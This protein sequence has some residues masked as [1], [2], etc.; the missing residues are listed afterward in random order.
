MAAFASSYIKTEGSQVT[1]SAD[2]A[3]M[4]GANFSSWY[5]ADEGTFFAEAISA[6]GVT[7]PTQGVVGVDDGST[8][9]N[10]FVGR[11]SILA[12]RLISRVGSVVDADITSG[13]WANLTTLRLAAALKTNDYALA[14]SSGAIST[15]TSVLMPTGMTRLMIGDHIFGGT[16]GGTIKKIAYYPKRIAN[17]ELQALTT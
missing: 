4:T 12:P 7:A 13:S 14:T 9:T 11:M 10:Y 5:R 16:F 17:A 15:D 3:S 1:R 6:R 2:A 8:A